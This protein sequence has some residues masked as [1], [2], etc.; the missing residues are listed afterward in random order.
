MHTSAPPINVPQ[1]DRGVMSGL[2]LHTIPKIP[3]LGGLPSTV[4][5]I[6]NPAESTFPPDFD[7][8]HLLSLCPLV[9]MTSTL[10]T[11]S[12]TLIWNTEVTLQNLS[13]D[14]QIS[15]DPNNPQSDTL[16]HCPVP[17]QIW[18]R[19]K[20]GTSI[21]PQPPRVTSLDPS[22]NNMTNINPNSIGSAESPSQIASPPANPDAG[23]EP[24]SISKNGSV[25]FSRSWPNS[26]QTS[27]EQNG[28]VAHVDD[29]ESSQLTL[30]EDKAVIQSSVTPESS[31]A[32]VCAKEEPPRPD[33]NIASSDGL[34]K[35]IVSRTLSHIQAQVLNRVHSV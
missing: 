4:R 18:T 32:P 11:A 9:S 2:Q 14:I 3:A 17:R 33:S 6:N 15:P 27:D 25:T 1:N 26:P 23:E 20:S 7:L 30:I 28:L 35:G 5:F 31:L 21:R 8:P 19:C 10:F 24:T 34:R 12:A 16:D 13:F 29:T 22:S